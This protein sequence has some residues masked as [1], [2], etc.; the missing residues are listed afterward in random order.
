[1]KRILILLTLFCLL[2]TACQPT[3]DE[4]AVTNRTDGTLLQAVVS[5]PVEAY[6][7][8]APARWDETFVPRNRE[9]RICADVEVPTA[10]QFPIVTIRRHRLTAG[11]VL[12]FLS[13]LCPGV[14]IVRENEYSREELTEDLKRA[15]NCYLGE[16]DE[17][18]EQIFGANEEEMRRIQKLIENA[19]AEDS[20]AP[21]TESGVTF[22]MRDIPVRDSRGAVWYL[23]AISKE[24]RSLLQLKRHRDTAVCTETMAKQTD[25]GIYRPE[26]L[27]NGTV[28]EQEAIR[29][30]DAAIAALGLSDYR[31]AD[32]E[33]AIEYQRGTLAEYSEG[34][35][36]HYVP[37]LEGTVP[38]WYAEARNPSFLQFTEDDIQT[39]YAPAW[40]QEA[41]E[42]Y[43]TEDGLVAFSWSDPKEHVM[44][45]NENVRLLPFEKIQGSIKKLLEYGLGNYGGS[46]VL[47]KRV[48]LT[49]SV[50]QIPDQGDE[51]F[52]VPTWA[53]FLTTEEDEAIH[54]GVCVLLINAMNGTYIVRN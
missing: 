19:P 52:L 20:F 36:L 31:V 40:T 13:A 54:S 41:A 35:L 45:A 3:P 33:K 24:T 9:I 1:M 22:P 2:F 6:T 12:D 7:Y 29:T 16:D 37:A 39:T 5:P 34:Y 27:L 11:D 26:G 48:V 21:L 28:S 4:E 30:G 10:E 32:A 49:T 8:D 51:A 43:V 46:P 44:T 25:A 15:S 14:W 38:C 47:V 53:V 17:T 23:T 42:L 18:G 50:A